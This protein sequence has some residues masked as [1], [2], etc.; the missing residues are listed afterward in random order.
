MIQVRRHDSRD[1][2]ALPDIDSTSAGNLS[3]DDHA[4]LDNVGCL[5]VQEQ[6]N[7]RFGV[8]LLHSHFPIRDGEM[9]V[10]EVSTDLQLI[11]L[12][13]VAE[14]YPGLVPTSVC[15]ERSGEAFG[16]IG[17]EFTPEGTLDGIR[18]LDAHDHDL[19]AS[20][21]KIVLRY[22]KIERFGIR[23]LHDPLGLGDRVLLETCDPHG[24]TCRTTTEADPDFAEAIP[25]L[26]QWEA[27]L[28]R[29]GL[30]AGQS[31]MQ[32]CKAMRKCSIGRDGHQSSSSHES[33][34]DDRY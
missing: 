12:R 23:L 9:L 33:S 8:T 20:V 34:H 31:C 15:F 13:P 21:H 6:A 25:T 19:L 5:L 11:T 1:Y 30:S 28:S 18:P 7:S 10:E 32:F 17:L 16:L 27:G 29:S 3:E 22:G 4:C 26:F 24:L 14:K 2:A